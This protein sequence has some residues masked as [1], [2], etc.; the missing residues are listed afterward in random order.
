MTSVYKERDRTISIVAEEDILLNF[1]D[2]LE[3]LKTSSHP[4]RNDVVGSEL[5]HFYKLYSRWRSGVSEELDWNKIK[6][7]PESMLLGYSSLKEVEH[8]DISK[9]LD[10]L[11][12]LKLNGG[13]GTGMGCVGP[14]SLIRVRDGATFLDVTVNQIETLN[15]EYNIN[16]P[17][18]L[19]NSL[20][21]DEE[22]KQALQK[23]LHLSKMFSKN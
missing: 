15:D 14:K 3:N 12:V 23:I 20:N 18:V 7:L 5:N 16:V 10:K 2:E 9:L 17:L 21:T 8:E 19:M 11:V 6:P 1:K 22:T 4:E 13:L